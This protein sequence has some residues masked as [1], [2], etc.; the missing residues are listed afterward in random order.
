MCAAMYPALWRCF[1]S[2]SVTEEV[3]HFPLEP[4]LAMAGED[5][6]GGEEMKFFRALEL[7]RLGGRGSRKAWGRKEES[8]ALL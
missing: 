3:S 7:E 8:F 1:T 2:F 4:E 5:G 6:G